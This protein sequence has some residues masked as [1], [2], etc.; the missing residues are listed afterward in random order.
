MIAGDRECQQASVFSGAL[1]AIARTHSARENSL[2]SVIRGELQPNFEGL[3]HNPRHK[4]RATPADI[5]I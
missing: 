3:R 4:I 1:L 2:A 5:Y